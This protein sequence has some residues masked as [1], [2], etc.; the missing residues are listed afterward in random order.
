[1]KFYTENKEE[2][3]FDF[4][5]IKQDIIDDTGKQGIIC[6]YKDKKCIK[7][8]YRE[9]PIGLKKHK[10]K[11]FNY[12]KELDL[13]NYCKL[14]EAFFRDPH[15]KTIGAYTMDYYKNSSSILD[16]PTE[17][18]LYN[19]QIHYENVKI[20]SEDKII[21]GD[22]HKNNV[23]VGDDD[24]T[25]I[26]FESYYKEYFLPYKTIL[27]ENTIILLNLMTSLYY[28]ELKKRNIL[29]NNSIY[30][31]DNLFYYTDE[32]VKT[33]SKKLSGKRKTIDLF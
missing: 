28:E 27:K 3:Y 6:K 23:I 22:L 25:I 17:Y 16:M 19:F 29:N 7:F 13:K 8:Y 1:M 15:L 4:D 21:M 18:L 30:V 32:P 14:H 2:I 11:T 9:Q 31:L 20:I 5:K 10:K 24:I 33:L 12:F 26:D